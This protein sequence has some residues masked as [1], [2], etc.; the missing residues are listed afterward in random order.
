M[1]SPQD[2]WDCVKNELDKPSFDKKQICDLYDEMR[3]SLGDQDAE[4][5]GDVSQE[6]YQGLLL[7]LMVQLGIDGGYDNRYNDNLS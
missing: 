5:H 6:I 4:G 2:W 7:T 3:S 1:W